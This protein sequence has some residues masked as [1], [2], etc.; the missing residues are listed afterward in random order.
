ML[1][2]VSLIIVTIY[3]TSMVFGP[4]FA[5]SYEAYASESKLT[6]TERL[7][8]M[9]EKIKV[10]RKNNVIS[11]SMLGI[12]AFILGRVM[13][14]N[15]PPSTSFITLGGFMYA[16]YSMVGW[17]LQ[18]GGVGATL[19]SLISGFTDET[20]IEY[21]YKITMKL[22]PDERDI[23]AEKQLEKFDKN[24]N[25]LDLNKTMMEVL[26]NDPSQ[27]IKKQNIDWRNLNLQTSN[28]ARPFYQKNLGK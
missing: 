8:N 3:F 23:Y 28:E 16:I 18:V 11:I 20:N 22:P 1:K 19:I 14:E 10:I 21:E 27:S 12:G 26:E 25:K 15:A 24:E 9:A 13:I 17:G 5:S 6:A 7:K 4:A 2:K